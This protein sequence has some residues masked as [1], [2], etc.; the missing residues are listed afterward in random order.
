[1]THEKKDKIVVSGGFDPIHVGHVRMIS[2]ASK[3]GSVTVVLNSDEW[4]MRKKGYIFMPWIERAEI[5]ESIQGVEN[6]VKVNDEDGTV[7][8]AL[9]RLKPAIFG[10]GGDRTRKNTPEMALCKKLGIKMVWSLG[11]NKKQSNINIRAAGGL[12]RTQD[13]NPDD[14]KPSKVEIVMSSDFAKDV[15]I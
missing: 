9:A 2:A 4:L 6:V 15:E 5:I 7:C 1:M 8:E 3:L 12:E 14:I 11:G 10:N 13:C